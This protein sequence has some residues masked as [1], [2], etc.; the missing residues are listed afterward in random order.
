HSGHNPRH[1]APTVD[2]NR[3]LIID[4]GSQFTQLIAR[5]VREERVYSEIHPPTRDLEWIREWAP[6]GIILSGGPSSVYGADVPT[7]EPELLRLGGTIFGLCCGMRLITPREVRVVERGRREDGR[8]QITVERPEGIFAGFDAGERTQVWM[9]HGDHV[10]DA[11]PGYR[12]LAST[13]DVPYAA[14]CSDE[15]KIYGVQ[16][17]P[18]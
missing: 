16:F 14:F 8:A 3:I 12:K 11:P 2:S 18:E 4:Y 6:K 15:R 17:H 1:P 10:K 5:R 13:P 9:S 7:A